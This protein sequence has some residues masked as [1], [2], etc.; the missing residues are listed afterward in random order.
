MVS[1]WSLL[2]P[3]FNALT[4]I[5]IVIAVL[6]LG[7]L[8]LSAIYLRGMGQLT[9]LVNSIGAVMLIAGV[10]FWVGVSFIQD[11]F[12]DP[13][14]TAIAISTII[15]GFVAFIALMPLMNK[16]KGKKKKR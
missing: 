5:G 2:F 3:N 7:I 15:V 16:K 6:G 9:K 14:L 12:S 1:I 11:I 10:V 8:I 13:K 4:L